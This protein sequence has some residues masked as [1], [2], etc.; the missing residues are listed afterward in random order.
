MQTNAH[1][2]SAYGGYCVFAK[3][4]DTDAASFSTVDAIARAVVNGAKPVISSFV[5]S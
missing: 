4:D 5:V 2:D 1:L 3:I